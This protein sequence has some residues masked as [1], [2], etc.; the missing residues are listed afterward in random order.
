MLQFLYSGVIYISN[1]PISACM[2]FISCTKILALEFLPSLIIT[3]YFVDRGV[4]CEE[5]I[6]AMLVSACSSTTAISTALFSVNF[7]SDNSRLW[8]LLSLNPH[9]NLSL[10][11]SSKLDLTY[12]RSYNTLLRLSAILAT[13]F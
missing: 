12:F 3:F 7:S 8:I 5:S 6:V 4:L 1:I 9:T 10:R 11:C 13:I 2:T